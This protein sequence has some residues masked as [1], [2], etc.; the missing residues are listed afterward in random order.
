M[1]FGVSMLA[2]QASSALR[3]GWTAAYVLWFTAWL[4]CE[5][6]FSHIPV[7]GWIVLSGWLLGMELWGVFSRRDKNT[8]SE[9]LWAFRSAG[10]ARG[11]LLVGVTVALCIRA[12][13]LWIM[14]N[15]AEPLTRWLALGPWACV[16]LGL[17]GWLL[18]HVLADGRYG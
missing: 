18:I 3:T 11:I 1:D 4:L 12:Y 8:L 16:A 15:T 14:I 5:A 6:F 2:S 7:W 13:S 10:W 9:Q 17:F